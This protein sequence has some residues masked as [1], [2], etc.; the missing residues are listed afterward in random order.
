M[1][2]TPSKEQKQFIELAK[3]GANI[4]VD[5][6]IG[7][8]KTTA[9]QKLCMSLPETTKILYLTYN[10]LLKL[11]AQSKIHAS[12]V[13]VQNYHGFAYTA[14][15]RAGISSGISDLIKTA[16][17]AEPY[18]PTYDVIIIDE[19]QDIE[20]ES[21]EFL[22]YIKSKNE[23]MQVIAV[24]DMEQKIYDKTT[25]DVV[26]F[27]HEFLGEY[28]QLE[29][30]Q[31][32]RLSSKHAES[33]GRIWG[34]Q[35]KGV[36]PDCEISTMDR[37]DV[38]EYLANQDPS[39]VMCLGS[40]TGVMSNTLNTLEQHYPE[41]YNKNTVYASIKN[42][43]GSVSP[44]PTS[45]IF[46]T[47]DSSKGL[48]R[49]ICVVFDYDTAYWYARVNKPQQKYEILRNIFLV[50]ASR[51]KSQIIFVQ[52][53]KETLNE[54]VLSTPSKTNT[55]FKD[56]TMSN[57]F[58]FKYREDIMKAYDMLD[59]EEFK[60][61]EEQDVIEIKRQDGLIDLSPCINLYQMETYFNNYSIDALLNQLYQ[62]KYK[63]NAPASVLLSPIDDKILNATSLRTNQMRYKHQVETPFV[64]ALGK[65]MLESRLA[66][67]FTKDEEVQVPS[68]LDFIGQKGRIFGAVGFA[69]VVKDGVV[70][71]LHFSNEL[72]PENYLECAC[73][74]LGTNHTES[75]IW[76]LSNNT[77]FK[78]SVPDETKFLN[79]VVRTA[80][81]GKHTKLK[82]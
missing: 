42:T 18:I 13:T 69:D 7:S 38:V 40:R 17:D 39:Q 5:A 32:F 80:T 72:T 16:V 24:G 15:S 23:S 61:T 49:D 14:L 63:H 66:T 37:Y 2:L 64:S 27:I 47:F 46:T 79:A 29:F 36:N 43:Q 31:C 4:L 57:L 56:T 48:E 62:N 67:R 76:N 55:T 19:Y 35:I 1:T 71:Q 65:K 26:P 9:I 52:S 51:G 60:L 11:D 70:Y 77:A 3:T 75:I 54:R 33:L 30:T 25:L 44:K 53:D 20:Q 50:A 59:I 74:M 68:T 45:A 12:N 58:E 82:K 8:G 73:N 41:K 78:V 6:C 28:T 34:K 22:K 21:S 81:K 10:K